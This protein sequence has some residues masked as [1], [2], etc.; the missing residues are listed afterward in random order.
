LATMEALSTEE[1]GISALFAHLKTGDEMKEIHLIFI[2]LIMAFVLCL[3]ACT[4]MNYEN[5]VPYNA[6]TEQIKEC[7]RIL[8]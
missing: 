5:C 8:K 7:E 1:I 3:K 4:V 6:T 2:G